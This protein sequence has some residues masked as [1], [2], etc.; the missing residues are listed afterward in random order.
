MTPTTRRTRPPPLQLQLLPLHLPPRLLPTHMLPT[1]MLQPLLPTHT[2][3]TLLPPT[4]MLVTATSSLLPLKTNGKRLL[5]LEPRTPTAT[6]FPA[7]TAKTLSKPVTRTKKR[8]RMA[9]SLTLRRRGRSMKSN[10]RRSTARTIRHM[11][12]IGSYIC[13]SGTAG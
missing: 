10:T 7:P 6:V 9:T 1:P 2:L 5:S 3:G 8:W 11:G 4:P 13:E 12:Y